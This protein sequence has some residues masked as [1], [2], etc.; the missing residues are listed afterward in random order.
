MTECFP[1][2]SPVAKEIQRLEFLDFMDVNKLFGRGCLGLQIEGKRKSR[3]A[4]KSD[5]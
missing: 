5:F 1:G 4:W 2:C 3:F